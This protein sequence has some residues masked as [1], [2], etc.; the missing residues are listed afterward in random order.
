MYKSRKKGLKYFIQ[1]I[2]N[3]LFFG[4]TKKSNNHS[5]KLRKKN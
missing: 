5:A 1:V 3:E 2:N 4:N